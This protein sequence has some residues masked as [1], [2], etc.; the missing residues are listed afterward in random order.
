MLK[1]RAKV[2][3]VKIT[4]MADKLITITVSKPPTIFDVNSVNICN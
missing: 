2:F 4:F 1:L 3:S